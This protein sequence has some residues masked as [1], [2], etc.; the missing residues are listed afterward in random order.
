LYSRLKSEN[1]QIIGIVLTREIKTR[2]QSEAGA[3]IARLS[4]A[5]GLYLGTEALG[6]GGRHGQSDFQLEGLHARL[7]SNRLDGVTWPTASSARRKGRPLN[8]KLAVSGKS[9]VANKV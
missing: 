7:L 3:S 9:I 1:R 4:D 2:L 5:W 6:L 8:A